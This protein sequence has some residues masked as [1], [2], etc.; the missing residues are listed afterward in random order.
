[1]STF[2]AWPFDNSFARLPKQFYSRLLPTPVADPQTIRINQVLAEQLELD[3]NWLVGT[4]GTAILAGN[5]LPKG[6]E[7]LAAAY[8]GHQFGS[9]NP[10]LGDGRAIL[11]GE[12]LTRNKHR[13]DIQL[14][15]SGP[16]PYSRNGDGRSPLG[17]VLREY[18]VS[19][20]MA[21]LGVP[22]SRAL[23]AVSTGE[24]VYRE[25]PLPGAV[26]TR[27]ASS[28]IRIGSFE[29]FSARKDT[30]SL[31]ALTRYVIERHYPE[32]ATT[33]NP[34]R[35]L[36]QSVV[37]RQAALIARWQLLGFIHGVMN[38]DNMLICGETIDYGPC[39]FMEY[40][41]PG[42]VFSSIDSNGRYAYRNQPGIG[43]WNLAVL[44][45]CL[46]PLLHPQQEHAVELAQAAIDSFNDHFLSSYH[47][48]L[49]T[50]LGWHGSH[51]DD[52]AMVQEL[53][54]LLADEP[55]DFT[56]F[57]RRL[58]DFAAP[59]NST[60]VEALQIMP[61]RFLPWLQ[62]W[63]ARCTQDNLNASERQRS[64]YRANPVFIPRN[65]LVEEAIAAAQNEGNFQPFHKLTERLLQPFDY[66]PTDEHYARPATT[67]E[68]VDR[69]F[70][71]T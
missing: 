19:E 29:Y 15:G 57:F 49:R 32:A 22:T 21:N 42:T 27:V 40:F 67:A 1:M 46:L 18:L 60:T 5:A 37:I 39:A 10:R 26:L 20:A 41:D 3:A 53:F 45:Q 2:T 70:C 23:A 28:H 50:K 69:T 62:R 56:L 8:A 16:T 44:A 71:G 59:N 54:T 43:Q 9:F 14:K 34:V 35:A 61:A 7:P 51:P 63:Q 30:N 25:R 65:H 33:D 13:F 68:R 64:M 36:L 11:L 4:D 24:R 6:A 38:T 12:V 47:E 55:T 58:A 52:E 66:D 31:Q 17:P 48:G